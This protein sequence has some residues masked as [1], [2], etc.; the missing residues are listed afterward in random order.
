MFQGLWKAFLVLS[1]LILS[2]LNLQLLLKTGARSNFF[3]DVDFTQ[4]SPFVPCI[5]SGVNVKPTGV[6]K[7]LCD[8]P[9]LTS[10]H[11]NNIFSRPLTSFTKVPEYAV[12]GN[13]AHSIQAEMDFH[14]CLCQYCFIDQVITSC[15]GLLIK[16]PWLNFAHTEFG[17][18]ASFVSLN[19]GMKIR[20]VSTSYR[21]TRVFEQCFHSLKALLI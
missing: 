14:H 12:T 17:G 5:I 19:K 2:K 1:L 8:Y 10:G 4:N 7:L 18:H 13:F 3:S 21:G 16:S 15:M 11:V 20:R 6:I 9:I